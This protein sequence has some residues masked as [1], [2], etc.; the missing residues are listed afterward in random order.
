VKVLPSTLKG[1]S[2]LP[3]LVICLLAVRLSSWSTERETY[4]VCFS[5]AEGASECLPF[6][7]SV[8]DI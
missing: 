7:S 6:Q 8:C 4:R 1:R 2:E 3:V 5:A